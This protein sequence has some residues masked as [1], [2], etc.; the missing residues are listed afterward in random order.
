MK[1][2]SLVLAMEKAGFTVVSD[3]DVSFQ[4]T[5]GD[6]VVSWGKQGDNAVCLWKGFVSKPPEVMHDLHPGASIKT[7]TDALSILKRGW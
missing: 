3:G 7:I 4:V 6:I 5:S 1:H 2:K